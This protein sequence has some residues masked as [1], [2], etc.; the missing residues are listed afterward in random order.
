MIFVTLSRLTKRTFF[1]SRRTS[2][3]SGR[4]IWAMSA[5]LCST[6]GPM[7]LISLILNM[8]WTTTWDPKSCPSWR[9]R[10]SLRFSGWLSSRLSF[11]AL[12]M[13]SLSTLDSFVR[14]TTCRDIGTQWL[15]IMN[16]SWFK[17]TMLLELIRTRRESSRLLKISVRRPRPR[18]GTVCLTHRSRC[19]QLT[20]QAPA[21]LIN[22]HLQTNT[23]IKILQV[24]NFSREI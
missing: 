2:S 3:S 7:S 1:S 11:H 15:R 18:R 17:T 23:I 16:R 8:F 5:S 19:I 13:S 21:M 10:W 22:R 20:S 4:K 6:L 9:D 12:P 24:E 14:S